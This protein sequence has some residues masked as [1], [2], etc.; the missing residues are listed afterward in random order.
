M[1]IL[2]FS[3]LSGKPRKF[4]KDDACIIPPAEVGAP[5]SM[6]GLGSV[7]A[8][9]LED[10]KATFVYSLSFLRLALFFP[11]RSVHFVSV[12]VFFHF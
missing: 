5:P 12:A 2:C 9:D 7:K 6:M 1:C 4:H 11:R 3:S 8:T 10:E